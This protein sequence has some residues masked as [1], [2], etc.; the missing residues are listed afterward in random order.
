MK[1]LRTA[2]VALVAALL[3]GPAL[4]AA[5]P[6]VR[7]ADYSQLKTPLPY[8]YDE[9]AN[10]DAQLAAAIAKAKAQKKRVLIDMGGNWCGDCRILAATMDLPEVKPWLDR[11]FVL[12]EIDV[13]R[14]DKN[15]Q[16]PAKYGI[17]E[18]LAGVPALLVYDPAT[19]KQ[20][21]S[22]AQV[23]A[24]EDARHLKPQD[25]INW[26]AQWTK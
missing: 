8:P 21:V 11:N 2:S 3:A 5:A 24:L 17:H 20:L 14:M 1:M 10:A 12:V 4:A 9:K 15:L 25:L 26:L 18:K 13:G 23:S 22:K 16:I 6:K 7:I 19:G